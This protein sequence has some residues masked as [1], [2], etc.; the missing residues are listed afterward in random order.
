MKRIVIIP[1]DKKPEGVDAK[2][3][4]AAKK[5][6][7]IECNY[8]TAIENIRNSGGLYMIKPDEKPEVQLAPLPEPE[9]MS[10]EDLAR[11]MS[12]WG[13]PLV[14]NKPVSRKKVVAAI[15]SFRENASKLIVDDD[16]GDD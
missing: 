5:A 16:S 3:F 7:A 9:D 4:A 11:E 12:Q 13:K 15:K 8:Q 10:V 14:G 6:G 1:V 2:T